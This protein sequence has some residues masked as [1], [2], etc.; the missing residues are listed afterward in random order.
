MCGYTYLEREIFTLIINTDSSRA[1]CIKARF[2]SINTALNDFDNA[3]DKSTAPIQEN[4][5]WELVNQISELDGWNN[6]NSL[7]LPPLNHAQSRYEVRGGAVANIPTD[8]LPIVD[9]FGNNRVVVDL[10]ADATTDVLTDRQAAEDG[11]THSTNGW[12]QT[13]VIWGGWIGNTEKTDT[14]D[15]LQGFETLTI[16]GQSGNNGTTPLYGISKYVVDLSLILRPLNGDPT[17]T[18]GPVRVNDATGQNLI[19]VALEPLLNAYNS[20]DTTGKVSGE[21][22]AIGTFDV[23]YRTAEMLFTSERDFDI[24]VVARDAFQV[25]DV[26]NSAQDFTLKYAQRF[27]AGVGDL[28]YELRFPRNI[29]SPLLDIQDIADEVTLFEEV[30]SSVQL[31]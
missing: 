8:N 6:G 13:D 3:E 23:N 26:T 16:M 29:R 25:V 14:S 31:E 10:K 28:E 17:I 1:F 15:P 27:V 22:A 2:T 7:G 20:A 11:L 4:I 18:V 12:V 30:G 24:S 21:T 9:I 5:R 19:D